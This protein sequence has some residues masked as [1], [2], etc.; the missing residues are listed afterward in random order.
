VGDLL[1]YGIL[2]DEG[3][4]LLK[5]GA[6]HGGWYYA[7]PDLDSASH[8]ELAAQSARVN[9]ALATLG[10][11]WML[12]VDAHRKP[13]GAY[14]LG[15]EHFPDP[16]TRLIEEE[17][18]IKYAEHGRHYE[19][20][21]AL[22]LT[23]KPPAEAERRLAAF[24]FEG[25]DERR[26]PGWE[27]LLEFFRRNLDQ[28]ED[29]L[30]AVLTLHRMDSEELLTHLHTCITGLHHRVRVPAIPAYLDSILGSQD[31]YGGFAPRIGRLHLRPV[32]LTGFPLE[33][34]PEILGFLNRIAIEYRWSNRFIF[35]N[36]HTAERH[37][38][39]YRR[40]WFQ[41]RMSLMGLVK[42]SFN[43]GSQTFANQDAVAMARDADEAVAEASSNTV[44][45]G[46]YTSVILVM[47]EDAS[48]ADA[49]ARELAK[50]LQ[51]H[52][53]PARIEETN[54]LEAYLGSLPGH[55]WPNVRRP[56]VHTL[57]LADF[58]PLTS[59]WSGLER[60]PCP[61][62][63]P[64]SPALVYA[65]T[66]STP[67]RLNLH[68][69][70]VGHTLVF[71]P[72]GSGKSTLL[73]LLMAQFFRYPD[74]R[75]FAFDKGYSSFILATAAGGEHHDFF[76]DAREGEEVAFHPLSG[77]DRTSER[78]WAEDWLESLLVLQG[79]LPS[80]AQRKALHRG[81]E[82]LGSAPPEARTLTDLVHTIQDQTLREGLH[83]YTL[84]GGLGAL[85]DAKT[86]SLGSARF[87]V[88]EMEQLMNMGDKN[89][90]P[91][92]LYL[93]HRIEQRLNA[94]S[95][96]LVVIDEAWVMLA[97]A[98]FGEKIEEW[99]RTLRKKNAA[100]VFASQSISEVVRSSKRDVVIESCPTKIFL[101][102]PEAETEH[103]RA[104]YRSLGLTGRQIEIVAH[105]VPKR[106]YYYVSPHGR[107]LVDLPL[108]PVTLAFTGAT[109][110]EDLQRA[111]ELT[112][113]DG[114]TWPRRWLRSRG[115][116]E[117]GERWLALHS[118][119]EGKCA[120]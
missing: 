5:D 118:G 96:T 88:F 82:L 57:N 19:S 117:A 98:L 84:A 48:V 21:Y 9:S 80:A 35:L 31:L 47:N 37:L 15:A 86:D 87:Q 95:P 45:F 10:N 36:P 110:R 90:V 119:G 115:L 109:G 51:H 33:S 39:S 94:G 64:E 67:F 30:S 52:G 4:L 25:E 43:M 100:V 6:F 53:I 17:R 78:L 69:S 46:Y 32:A 58:L 77:V 12:N 113:D 22:T 72:T 63:P 73:G 28:I 105:A 68:V 114:A 65:A 34:Y 62:F 76:G 66:S 50:E 93:F 2:A 120:A 99:L 89:L 70:D 26:R 101:P 59:V 71:G 107:R 112:R 91:V 11:G 49:S 81:V 42:E 7:G 60:N 1:N 41:K 20:V 116:E 74:A 61:Y 23:Y 75:V 111:R 54:A 38:R 40:N 14:P 97:H 18:D 103:S 92:L 24:L 16:T 106:Q 104:L 3:I 13:A 85:F 56:L 29:L 27:Q 83:H 44:R 108:D 55:G 8:E 102:N 79:I